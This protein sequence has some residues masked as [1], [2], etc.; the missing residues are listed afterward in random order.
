MVN[1]IARDDDEM[2]TRHQT[3]R[4]QMIIGDHFIYF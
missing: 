1:D 3:I 4:N 2:H